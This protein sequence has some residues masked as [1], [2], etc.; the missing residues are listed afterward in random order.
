MTH[1]SVVLSTSSSTATTLPFKCRIDSLPS[2]PNLLFPFPRP[3]FN[4]TTTN[5]I[6]PPVADS[7]KW[8]NMVSFFPGFLK[9]GRD[10]QSLKVELYE[11]IAPLDRGAEATPEDQQRVDQVQEVKTNSNIML[12]TCIIVCDFN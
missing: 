12:I 1:L 2:Q 8:R 5:I 7:G 10:V 4:T 11:A 9:G 6:V 3:K